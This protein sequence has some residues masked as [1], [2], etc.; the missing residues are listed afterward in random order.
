MP[1]HERGAI[2]P[3][4]AALVAQLVGDRTDEKDAPAPRRGRFQGRREDGIWRLPGIEETAIILDHDEKLPGT[5]FQGNG[6]GDGT[7]SIAAMPNDVGHELVE[8]KLGFSKAL[9][10]QAG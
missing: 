2:P 9:R 5:S 1:E 10:R 8:A 4:F 6:Q 7:S 3:P